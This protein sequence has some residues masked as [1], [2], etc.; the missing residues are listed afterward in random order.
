MTAGPPLFSIICCLGESSSEALSASVESVVAQTCAEWELLLVDDG[1]AGTT[2]QRQFSS[3]SGRPGVRIVH[4]DAAQ[5]AHVAHA[6]NAAVEAARGEF[7]ALLDR[8]DL[9]SAD[10]L[11]HV[12]SIVRGGNGVDVVYTDEE[13]VR[14]DG[15]RTELAKP[16]W[17]PERLRSQSY[18]EH[19]AVLRTTLVREV[20]G[21]RPGF[22]GAEVHDLLL[23][24]TE[25]SRRIE[26][27]ARPLYRRRS[28]ALEQA[29]QAG[30]ADAGRRA[31]QE[32]LDRIGTAGTVEVNGPGCFRTRRPLPAER[33][34]S[35]VIPTRGSDALVWGRRTT[36]VCRAV[37]SALAMTHHEDLEIVVV[38]D[39]PTPRPVLEELRAIAGDKLR[40]VPFDEPFNYSRKMNLGVL[41]SSGDR[42]ILLNDDIEVRSEG[43]VEE[44]LAPL[45]QPD[46][47]VTGAKLFFSSTAIQHAGLAFSNGRY[48]HPYRRAPE[49]TTGPSMELMIDREVTGVTGACVGIRREVY[50][51]VGGLTEGLKESFND[52]DF[53]YKIA[54]AGYRSLYLAHCRLF[55]FESQTR[56]P[57]PNPDDDRFVRARWGIP[58][59]D[60]FTPEYPDRPTWPDRNI[61]LKRRA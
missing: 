38:H 48:V 49:D 33:R 5:A 39:T 52:V 16:Q 8:G 42:L 40:L 55:H 45:E 9:L 14:P 47:G 46:V 25:R 34:V 59:R 11:A 43:W 36:L 22:E 18:C 60:R 31:V 21:L 56:D 20:G 61:N 41:A 13:I 19:L 35:I 15:G 4:L 3:L 51:E 7:I 24:V 50:L 37:R 30:A 53:A 2:M 12:A 29:A 54:N 27:I 32:H 10:A 23:R 28:A 17:S 1:S 44:L 6:W 26:H 58:T 57:V